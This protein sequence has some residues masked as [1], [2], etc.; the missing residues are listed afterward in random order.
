M[1]NLVKTFLF[2]QQN[3]PANNAFVFSSAYAMKCP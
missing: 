3:Q 2:S 1:A